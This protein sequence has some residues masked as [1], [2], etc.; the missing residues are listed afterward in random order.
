[1]PLLVVKLPLRQAAVKQ[2]NWRG[3]LTEVEGIA[4]SNAEREARLRC[5]ILSGLE[6]EMPKKIE[7]GDEVVVR[8]G[9]RSKRTAGS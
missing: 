4:V 5:F 8:G 1:M 6:V 7:V 3:G 2:G 9:V